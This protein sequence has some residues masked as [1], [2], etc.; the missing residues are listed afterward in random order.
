MERHHLHY[1][2]MRLS[3]PKNGSHNAKYDVTHT[4]VYTRVYQGK[5]MMRFTIVIIKDSTE[6]TN[7]LTKHMGAMRWKDSLETV[8]ASS[9]LAPCFAII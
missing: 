4:K 1:G 8:L 2:V 9:P 7:K 6:E 3:I 5:H